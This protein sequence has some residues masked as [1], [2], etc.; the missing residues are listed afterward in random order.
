MSRCCSS[1]AVEEGGVDM[2][3]SHELGFIAGTQMGAFFVGLSSIKYM[4]FVWVSFVE[5]VYA[6]DTRHFLL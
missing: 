3:H 5:S 6:L 1:S 2:A 4:S